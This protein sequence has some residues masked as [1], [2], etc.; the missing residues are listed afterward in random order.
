M[1]MEC[2][3]NMRMVLTLML[4]KKL[5]VDKDRSY[6]EVHKGSSFMVVCKIGMHLA[7]GMGKSSL[8]L[9]DI[10]NYSMMLECKDN[11]LKEESY[12]RNIH[13][14]E[15]MGRSYLVQHTNSKL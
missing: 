5:E 13:L 9:M 15:G 3:D 14:L 7:V 10:M 8:V 2:M 11:M 1:G 12:Q 4:S 6:L